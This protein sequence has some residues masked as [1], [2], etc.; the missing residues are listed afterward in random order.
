MDDK[1]LE[2]RLSNYIEQIVSNGSASACAELNLEG[3]LRHQLQ[4]SVQ[5]IT[6]VHTQIRMRRAVQ[7]LGHERPIRL[8]RDIVNRDWTFPSFEEECSDG[9]Q[10]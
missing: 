4:L 7:L 6:V 8:A 2:R 5:E 1:Y 10:S 3:I 9:D